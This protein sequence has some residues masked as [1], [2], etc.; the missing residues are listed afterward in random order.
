MSRANT[1]RRAADAIAPVLRRTVGPPLNT[2]LGSPAGP[3]AE[4]G[5][6]IVTREP[7]RLAAVGPVQTVLPV[8]REPVGPDPTFNPRPRS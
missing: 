5:P 1:A 8:A 4:L 6:G 3:S 2:V 7:V